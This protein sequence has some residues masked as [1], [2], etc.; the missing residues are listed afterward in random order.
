MKWLAAHTWL[1][2]LVPLVAV[3]M[4]SGYFG[5]PLNLLKDTEISYLGRDTILAMRLLCEGQDRVKT[6]RYEAEIEDGKKVLLYL[7]RD[8]LSMPIAGD[9]LMVQTTVRRGGKLGEFDYGL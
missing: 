4:L 1:I 9:I 3:I 8:S 7:Q 6:I 2:A 5:K